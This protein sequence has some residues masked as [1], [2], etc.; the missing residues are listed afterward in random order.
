MLL[1]RSRFL[2]SSVRTLSRLLVVVGVLASYLLAVQGAYRWLTGVAR[3]AEESESTTS[4][5]I[6]RVVFLLLAGFGLLGALV[7]S[8]V[9]LTPPE[10]PAPTSRGLDLPVPPDGVNEVHYDVGDATVTIV[11]VQHDAAAASDA[12]SARP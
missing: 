7:G 3:G 2:E 10:P 9:A 12:A 8:F 11:R 1:W 6:G 5:R 4:G